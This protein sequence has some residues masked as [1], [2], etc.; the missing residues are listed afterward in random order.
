METILALAIVAQLVLGGLVIAFGLV[1]P[2]IAIVNCAGSSLSKNAKIVWIVFMIC[3]FPLVAYIYF[4][5]HAKTRTRRVLSAL[6]LLGGI[7][8]FAGMVF[9]TVGKVSDKIEEAKTAENSNSSNVLESADSIQ[10]IQKDIQDTKKNVQL[11]I[12]ALTISRVESNLAMPN[13]DKEVVNMVMLDLYTLEDEIKQSALP[14]MDSIYFKKL[15]DL[16]TQVKT[17]ADIAEWQKT[18]SAR[19]DPVANSPAVPPAAPASS[20]TAPQQ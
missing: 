14:N 7:L 9:F 2:V 20:L 3:F 8:V 19:K 18:F 1:L 6:V 5:R 12:L 10:S 11:N 17:K 16:S 4:A 15:C 13:A